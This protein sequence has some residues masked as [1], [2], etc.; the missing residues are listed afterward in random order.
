MIS[1]EFLS[2][3]M[4][5]SHSNHCIALVPA[6][7][8]LFKTESLIWVEPAHPE[9]GFKFWF[10]SSFLFSPIALFFLYLDLW[11][12]LGIQL[13]Y[14]FW[15]SFYPFLSTVI[16][17]KAPVPRW[18]YICLPQ[19]LSSIMPLKTTLQWQFVHWLWI[20]ITW[21]EIHIHYLLAM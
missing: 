20:D 6:K 8:F 15:A 7:F 4:Y 18:L 9:I 5:F 17:F 14:D 1:P 19:I 21:T 10:F 16:W 12:N 2:F 11:S 13:D 3:D